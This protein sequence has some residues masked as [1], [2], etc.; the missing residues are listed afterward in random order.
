MPKELFLNTPKA[1]CGI[2]ESRMMII[3]CLKESKYSQY[4]F[5]VMS[6]VKSNESYI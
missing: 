6:N 5:D 1:Q 3:L 4:L 2:H